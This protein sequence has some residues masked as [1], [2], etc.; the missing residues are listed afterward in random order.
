MKL[1]SCNQTEE[2]TSEQAVL[3]ELGNPKLKLKKL[4]K[5]TNNCLVSTY[6]DTDM[7]NANASFVH[8]EI[9]VLHCMCCVSAKLD[10]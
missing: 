3:K 10:V 1:T 6:Q 8:K 7:S 2:G 4:P 9:K 5:E